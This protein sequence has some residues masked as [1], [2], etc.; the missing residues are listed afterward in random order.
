M[1]KISLQNP[2][3]ARQLAKDFEISLLVI[4]QGEEQVLLD[5][6]HC[7]AALEGEEIELNGYR[8]DLQDIPESLAVEVQRLHGGL[9]IF[10]DSVCKAFIYSASKANPSLPALGNVPELEYLS[11]SGD[12]PW[13]EVGEY[14]MLKGL[15]INHNEVLTDLQ[16]L[17]KL[18]NLEWLILY[19]C[20]VSNLTP[21]AKLNKLTNIILYYC[22]SVTDLTPL[23][24]LNN[25]TQIA[26]YVCEA[27][28]DIAPLANLNNLA[29]VYLSGCQ[30]VTDLT[31]LAKLTNLLKIDLSNCQSITDLTPLGELNKLTKID[32]SHSQS[33]SDLTP[34]ATLTDLLEIN[35][36]HTAITNLTPLANLTE[37]T[38]IDIGKCE[39]LTD[40]TPLVNLTNLIKLNIGNKPHITSITPLS[41]LPN[42]RWLHCSD[43]PNIHDFEQL[44]TLPQ[45]RYLSWDQAP[46]V[47]YVL[48]G[49]AC[50]REDADFIEAHIGQWLADAPL[51]GNVEKYGLRLIAVC[52]VSGV[53]RAR[54]L[55]AIGQLLRD[56]GTISGRAVPRSV[57]AQY[58]RAAFDTG[59]DTLQACYAIALEG[60]D[61]ERELESLLYPLLVGL[62]GLPDAY[63][64]C[65]PWAVELVGHTL[66]PIKESEEQAKRIAPAAAACYAGWGDADNARDWMEKGAHPGAPQWRDRVREARR[67]YHEKNQET[68]SPLPL[69]QLFLLASSP[70]VCDALGMGNLESLRDEFL[71]ND[72]ED[73]K[74]RYQRFLDAL[75]TLELL[76]PRTIAYLSKNL[77]KM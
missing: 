70:Q 43:C 53:P 6:Q 30:S 69:R 8:F 39:S 55:P 28:S 25:L 16:P 45:L 51:A 15:A 59:P 46:L 5:G 29:G 11:L 38:E 62:A 67:T 3:K 19:G 31:P 32:L 58:A 60:F 41:G 27:I 44:E 77:E 24:N 49:S 14:T 40:L 23:A 37:L 68:P 71:P 72:A 42:L 74:N 65:L 52:E 2:E 36:F 75:D 73:K 17:V 50:L 76:P 12:S 57:W 1:A 35:L 64:E 4:K 56:I 47:H 20:R 61:P 33:L 22:D 10:F 34:L 9:G 18:I 13:E 7:Q 48:M 66:N 26:L 54:H 63:P 21:L